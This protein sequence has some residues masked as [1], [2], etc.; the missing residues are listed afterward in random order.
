MPCEL[1]FPDCVKTAETFVRDTGFGQRPK[2][3]HVCHICALEFQWWRD[4][5]ADVCDCQ[6]HMNE[7][8]R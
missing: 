2:D 7:A 3:L 6:D 1:S 8:R 4:Q 5:E